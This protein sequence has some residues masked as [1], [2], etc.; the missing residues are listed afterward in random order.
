MSTVPDEPPR[1][2]AAQQST[3]QHVVAQTTVDSAA[4]ADQLARRVVE[5]G[6]AACVQIS[7]VRSVFA[8]DGAV[9]QEPEQL[10]AVKTTT[11]AV[12]ALRALLDAEHPYDEPE[13]VVLPIVD[14]SPSYLA[15]VA[16]SVDPG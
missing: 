13:L 2:P 3:A 16:E 5:A 14:G 12:D 9:Q 7:E 6:L 10:L 1:D 4:R 8:W 11:A 15:W